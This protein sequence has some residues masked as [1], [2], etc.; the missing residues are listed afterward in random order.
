MT[1][2]QAAPKKVDGIGPLTREGMPMSM[3]SVSEPTMYV[4]LNE[5]HE[6]F[7]SPQEVTDMN[8]DLWYKK[9]YN[10]IHKAKDDGNYEVIRALTCCYP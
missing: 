9:M 1:S 10:T 7:Q 3:R 6:H 8:R 5:I 4:L 2:T